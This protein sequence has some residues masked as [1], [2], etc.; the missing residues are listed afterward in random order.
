MRAYSKHKSN[1]GLPMEKIRVPAK[2]NGGRRS[3]HDRRQYSYSVHIPERRNG[4][5]RRSGQDRRKGIRYME[6]DPDASE[7][8]DFLWMPRRRATEFLSETIGKRDD[9]NIA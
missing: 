1:T 5:E 2:D 8:S 9:R 3:G 6:V 4:P 7:N